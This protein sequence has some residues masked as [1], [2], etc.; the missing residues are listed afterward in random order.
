MKLAFIAPVLDRV[1]FV[2]GRI[3]TPGCMQ[4]SLGDDE[5]RHEPYVSHFRR[6][7]TASFAGYL[8]DASARG[9]FLFVPELLSP[10]IFYGRVFP[11]REGV[12][13]RKATAGPTR[14]PSAGSPA[15]AGPRPRRAESASRVRQ[16]R[17]GSF[18][19]RS[20]CAHTP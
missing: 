1:R 5:S 18:I 9:P 6:L 7:W 19:Q 8:R 11:G 14:S 15:S 17:R 4:V 20:T 12:P 2:H 3:G 13:A 10:R 16:R